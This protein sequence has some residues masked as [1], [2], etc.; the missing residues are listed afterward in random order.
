[1]IKISP[2]GKE[3]TDDEMQQIFTKYNATRESI[4]RRYEMNEVIEYTKGLGVEVGC[5]LNK[6]HTGAIGINLVLS[7]MDFGYPFGAQIKADGIS[8]PWFTDNS[9]DY[10]FSSHCLEHFHEPEKALKEW[11][12]VIRE[13][14]YLVLILPH[15]NYYPNI[16]H[17]QA[18]KDHK[19]D[20]LPEDVKKII[21]EI[22]KYEIIRIDTLHDKLKDNKIAITEASKYGHNTLN[23]SFEIVAKKIK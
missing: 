7:D 8:L 6:I 20:F 2:Y 17:P 13:G 16:G 4:F 11:T 5:G 19:H 10:L 22:G 3:I 12:R 21:D 14:G 1:M 15:K 23:F 18:N 9:L